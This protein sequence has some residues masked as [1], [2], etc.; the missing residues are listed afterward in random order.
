MTYIYRMRILLSDG[1]GLTSRQCARLL[2]ARGH[3][4]GVLSPDPV[5]LSRFTRATEHV[6]RVPPYG[7]APLA[8]LD[9]ALA[10]YREHRYDVLFPT[11]EQV[12]L[13]A[14]VP[15]RLAEKGV[16]TAVPSFAAVRAVQDKVSAHSTL[17]RLAIPEP[18]TEVF[19]DAQAAAGW[20]VFPAFLKTPIGTATSGVERVTSPAELDRALRDL[21]A[22]GWPPEGV[23]LQEQ[24]DGDLAMVQSV[25]ARGELVAFHANRRTRLG[26]NGGASHKESVDLPDVREHFETL[27]GDLG[28]HGALSADVILAAAGAQVIDVNPRLVEPGN[29]WRSGVDLVGTLLD[30]AL[31]RTPAPQPTGRAGVRTHQLLLAVLGAAQQGRGRRGVLRE[32]SAARRHRG[33]YADSTEE[34]TPVHRDRLA[35]IPV[36]LAVAA[37]LVRPRAWTWFASG[38]VKAYALTPGAWQEI[39]ARS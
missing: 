11:Q 27:G 13:L 15:E 17:A 34:L 29:A 9:A 28:W 21:E 22:S 7:A 32:L 33:S 16:V 14:A 5:C 18:R 12:A 6:H 35:P 39:C 20:D 1:S 10:T 38:S 23:V 26:A 8:W 3:H 37:T 19:T 24:A 31:D 25:F 30:V 36:A 4:V 2:A